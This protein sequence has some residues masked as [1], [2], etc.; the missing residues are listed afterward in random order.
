MAVIHYRFRSV[1]GP[2]DQQVGTLIFSD[3]FDRLDG[4]R[5][6]IKTNVSSLIGDLNIDGRHG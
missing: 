3:D 5:I 2:S 1:H 4:A 6:P